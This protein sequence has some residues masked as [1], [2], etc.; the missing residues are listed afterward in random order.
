[1][2]DYSENV[3]IGYDGENVWGNAGLNLQDYIAPL[4]YC[5]M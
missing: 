5:L 1:M 4:I 3:Y 2:Y